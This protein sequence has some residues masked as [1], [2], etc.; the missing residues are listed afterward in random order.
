MA[1]GNETSP[2]KARA[3]KY[4][5]RGFRV[6]PMHA[7]QDGRC[8]CSKG[9]RCGRPGKHPMTTHGVNDATT[10]RGR[11][12]AWWKES[13]DANIGIAAGGEAGILVLDIDPR[14]KGKET[15]ARLKKDLGP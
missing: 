11:I 4:A 5:A 8:S 2:R 3:L 13:P 9:K 1:L 12:E 7:V 15:L 10:D 6:V 14:N